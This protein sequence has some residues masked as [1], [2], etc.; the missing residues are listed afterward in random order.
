MTRMSLREEAA[1]RHWLRCCFAGN[2]PFFTPRT[3]PLD[4]LFFRRIFSNL[5]G[6]YGNERGEVPVSIFQRSVVRLFTILG[7]SGIEFDASEYDVDGS[8]A[9]GWYEFVTCWRRSQISA[10]LSVP[11]QAFFAMEDP[12]TCVFGQLASIVIT[13][14]IFVSC[15]SFIIGTLPNLKE[16]PFECLECEPEQPAVFDMLE[17]VC[18]SVFTVEYLVRLVLAPLSRSELLDYER[19]LEFVTEHEEMS[20]P[21]PWMRFLQF[22]G[23]PMNVIDLLVI[24]PYYVEFFVA[25]ATSNLTVLRVLRLTRLFRLVKLGKYFEILQLTGRVFHKAVKVLNVLFIYLVLAVCFASA[26]MFYVEGGS[27]DPDTRDF[28]RTGHDGVRSSSPFKS[29]PHT[30]WWCVVTFTTVGYGDVYPVTTLGKLVATCTMV[31]GILVLAMPIS[32]V[33]TVWQEVWH[34][35]NEE[36]RLESEAQEQDVLSVYEALASLTNRTRLLIELF[37]EDLGNQE[38]ECLGQAECCNLPVESPVLVR[39]S[40]TLPLRP[41]S[42][43]TGKVAGELFISCTWNPEPLTDDEESAL[44]SILGSLE[45]K[46]HRATGL[47]RSDWKASGQRDVYAVVHCWPKPACNP[48][49]QSIASEQRRTQTIHSTLEPAWEEVFSFDYQWPKDNVQ[50]LMEKPVSCRSLAQASPT[51]QRP[52]SPDTL[53][54]QHLVGPPPEQRCGAGAA[55]HAAGVGHVPRSGRSPRQPVS[56]QVLSGGKSLREVVEAQ[57]REISLLAGCVTEMRELLGGLS[58]GADGANRSDRDTRTL[59]PGCDDTCMLTSGVRGA[60]ATADPKQSLSLGVDGSG[61]HVLLKVESLKNC[62]DAL[63][64]SASPPS[65][66]SA[67]PAMGTQLSAQEVPGSV[68]VE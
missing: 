39:N 28:M 22:V 48:T 60:V 50:D 12:G 24:V 23:Q 62:M 64:T 57:R 67:L 19:I 1:H 27:W 36:R 54:D 38:P 5:H 44:S 33:S 63:A 55:E 61:P 20:I 34:G 9:V 25:T 18:V 35:W 15:V 6:R 7:M 3:V 2:K 53:V 66:D 43:K 59:Q 16:T 51:C 49:C 68:N 42:S 58:G 10:T 4:L 14:L 8:H 31:S 45:V 11:E 52:N 26:G 13:T 40:S 37:D 32:I 30:F 41:S 56:E 47:L 46:V 17:A 65:L 21:S 29:I